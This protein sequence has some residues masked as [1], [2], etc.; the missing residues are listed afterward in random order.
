MAK[1]PAK[2]STVKVTAC[3]DFE[4]DKK[5]TGTMTLWGIEFTAEKGKLTAEVDAD[6][7]KAMK[8]AKKCK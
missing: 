3:P 2:K 6:I 1:A 8:D 4:I 7:A 5:E